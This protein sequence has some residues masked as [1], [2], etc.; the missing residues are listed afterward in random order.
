MKAE[1]VKK[2]KIQA[3]L[4]IVDTQGRR[5]REVLRK[6]S[7]LEPEKTIILLE[8]KEGPASASAG[9]TFLFL[10]FTFCYAELKIESVIRDRR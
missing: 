9:C 3:Q 6:G 8:Q 1:R 7:T 4:Q 5:R 10:F 2:Q